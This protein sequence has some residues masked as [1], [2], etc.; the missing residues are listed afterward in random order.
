[1][2]DFRVAVAQVVGSWGFRLL[3]HSPQSI[4]KVAKYSKYA[5]PEEYFFK[6]FRRRPFMLG[7]IRLR[8]RDRFKFKIQNSKFKIKPHVGLFI[9]P[10]RHS[11]LAPS[12][13]AK[14][15][16]PPSQFP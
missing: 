7:R 11:V 14:F 16:T 9:A 8:R 2:S 4:T 6:F 5:P 13:L 15:A 12:A 10:A 3:T 1:M